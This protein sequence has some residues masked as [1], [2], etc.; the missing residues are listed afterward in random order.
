[1]AW[2][3]SAMRKLLPRYIDQQLTLNTAVSMLAEIDRRSNPNAFTKDGNGI[4]HILRHLTWFRLWQRTR[5]TQIALE[6]SN[7]FWF[8]LN[9]QQRTALTKSRRAISASA[10]TPQT[11]DIL[12]SLTPWP[13]AMRIA[14]TTEHGDTYTDDIMDPVIDHLEE[15]GLQV[16]RLIVIA[17]FHQNLLS[18]RPLKNTEEH[19]EYRRRRRS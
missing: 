8:G 7:P 3:K 1:M 14:N 9:T 19:K 12:A 17:R 11:P 10:L 18:R 16:Q 5:S 2:I 6:Q 15:N 13:T 4:Y